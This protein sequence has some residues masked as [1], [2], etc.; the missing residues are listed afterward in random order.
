MIRRSG[1][2]HGRSDRLSKVLIVSYCGLCRQSPLHHFTFQERATHT[3][4]VATRSSGRSGDT[5]SKPTKAK[6]AATGQLAKTQ[7]RISSS[8]R[9]GKS[10]SAKESNSQHQQ[11]IKK[12]TKAK[13]WNDMSHL[14]LKRFAD[15][16]PSLTAGAKRDRARHPFPA[17]A[18]VDPS[19]RS[20]CK[21]C[22]ATIPK[23]VLRLSL[24]LECHKGYRNLCTLHDYCFWQHPETKKLRGVDE[25]SMKGLD[26]KQRARVRAAFADFLQKEKGQKEKK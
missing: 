5:K 14:S 4:A 2:S 10:S 25:I 9:A 8:S 17:C 7:P 11:Q 26:G 13:G 15:D 21:R 24:L 19:G 18:A 20:A 6:A 23:G 12:E 22:G 3:M 1:K 16:D